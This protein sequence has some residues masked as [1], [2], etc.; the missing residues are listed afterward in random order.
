MRLDAFCPLHEYDRNACEWTC[1]DLRREFKKLAH[2]LNVYWYDRK[3]GV[4]Y[5]PLATQLRCQECHRWFTKYRA[6]QVYCTV[7]CRR[8]RQWFRYS[9]KVGPGNRPNVRKRAA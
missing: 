4:R 8:R 5:T 7:S 6:G 1:Y 3:H 9:E 2:A